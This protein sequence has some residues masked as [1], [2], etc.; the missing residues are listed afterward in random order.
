M[1]G[2]GSDEIYVLETAEALFARYVPQADCLIH[3]RRQDKVILMT[4]NSVIIESINKQ[5]NKNT[6]DHET[7]RRSDVCAE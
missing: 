6:L 5:A 2:N 1:K 4:D 3:G 7:S